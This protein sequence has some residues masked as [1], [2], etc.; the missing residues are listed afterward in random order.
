MTVFTHTEVFVGAFVVHLGGVVAMGVDP[1]RRVRPRRGQCL[2]WP[3]SW[4]TTDRLPVDALCEACANVSTAFDG[5]MVIDRIVPC[6]GLFSNKKNLS[7]YSLQPSIDRAC[8][9]VK[10]TK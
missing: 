3:S 8:T 2:F 4:T 7:R 1:H 9:G 5:R 6:W 10:S